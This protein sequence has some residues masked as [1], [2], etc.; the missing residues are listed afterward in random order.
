MAEYADLLNKSPKT[1]S[2]VF[3]KL[4]TKSPLQFIQDRKMLEARRL[5]HY[6]EL[7]VGEVAYEIGF[8]NVQTFSRFFKKN[9][10]VSPSEFKNSPV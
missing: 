1:I 8:D 10:G 7:P 4:G 5:L 3:S 2:N 6:S 9:E